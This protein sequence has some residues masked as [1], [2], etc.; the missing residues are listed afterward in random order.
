MGAEGGLWERG[1]GWVWHGGACHSCSPL[2]SASTVA[3][4]L[5]GF[6]WHNCVS[7]RGAICHLV[8]KPK[9][10]SVLEVTFSL[11]KEGMMIYYQVTE[12]WTLAQI[13]SHSGN[14]L[15]ELCWFLKNIHEHLCCTN[16]P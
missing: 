2:V 6:M 11:A 14:V 9:W 12:F 10:M 5:A 13:C 15:T 4:R 7:W 1:G 16:D 8:E 3:P